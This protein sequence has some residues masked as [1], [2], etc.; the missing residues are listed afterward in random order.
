[1]INGKTVLSAKRELKSCKDRKTVA[2]MKVIV[3]GVPFSA[4][5]DYN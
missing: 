1:M 2:S 5:C 4:F 3:Y